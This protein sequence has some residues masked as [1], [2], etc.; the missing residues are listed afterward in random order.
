L[1]IKEVIVERNIPKR[2]RILTG[3]R[4][5]ARLH[6][7]HYVGTLVN[8]V[9]LQNDYDTYV[10]IADVQALSTHWEHPEIMPDTVRQVAL[11]YLAVGIDPGV[12][13]ICVQS[14]SPQIAELTV[15]YGL[16]TRMNKLRHNPTLKSEAQQY[17]Y[18]KGED[19]IGG[20]DKLTY[21]FFGYPISQAADITFVRADLVPVGEDQ[22]PHIELCRDIVG[23]FN[24]LYGRG[25]EII[26]LPQALVGDVPRLPGLDGET[27][28]SKSLGN[29]VFLSDSD[30]E[31]E[32]AVM[33]AITDP[34]KIRR[35]DP[36]RPEVCNVFAY[37]KAFTPRDEVAEIA[38]ECR[39]G[40]LGCVADK[41]RLAEI[42]KQLIGPF[43]EKRAEWEQRPDDV[44]DILRRGTEAACNEGEKTL[45]RIKEAMSIGYW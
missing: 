20:F 35:G 41:K 40:T 29:A 42:L 30:Q 24:Q 25:E 4:P 45:S 28:M 19:L 32:K 23:R 38:A 43:R 21:G 18:M 26:P 37:H 8:R 13:T 16:F 31:I 36:G 9:K 10:L 12:C 33:K 17:G 5:T 3:D 11:D 2:K 7:G 22:E 44:I 27:K 39:K 34:Q 1:R 15:I 6:L 14:M